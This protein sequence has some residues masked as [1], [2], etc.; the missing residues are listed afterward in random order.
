MFQRNLGQYQDTALTEPVAITSHGRERLVL[1]SAEEYR[2]LKQRAREVL[3]VSELT[4]D[5]IT[6]LEATHMSGE[7]NHLNAEFNNKS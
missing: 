5:D 3:H 7:H 4:D 2:H 1:L 6:Q